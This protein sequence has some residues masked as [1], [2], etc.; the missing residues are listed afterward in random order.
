VKV[1]RAPCPSG[2][3]GA[4]VMILSVDNGLIVRLRELHECHV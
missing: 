2:G 3:A 1:M 4:A